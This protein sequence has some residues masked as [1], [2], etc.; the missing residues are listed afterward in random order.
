[1]EILEKEIEKETLLQKAEVIGDHFVSTAI[2]DKSK[3][4]CNWLGAR[5]IQDRQIA[6]YANRISALSPEFYSGSAGVAYFLMELYA[7]SQKGAYKRTAIAA[8]L[9]SAQYM[10]VNEFP[11][12]SISFYAGELGLIYIAYRFMEIAPEVKEEIKEQLDGLTSK[13]ERG[14][15]VNHSLDVIGG[16]SGAI[17]V[18]LHLKR[19]YGLPIFEKTALDCANEIV[20]LGN[21]KDDICVWSSP[22]VHGV[23]LD[24]PPT[25]GYS[26]G[27]SGIGV[28]LL[29]AYH[30]TKDKNYLRYG[31]GA[32]AF[33][34]ALFNEE[35]GNWIDTRYPH[36]KR[37]GQIT[38]TFRAAWCHGAP[39]IALANLRASFLDEERRDFHLKM[40]GIAIETT[41]AALINKIEEEPNKDATLCH[42][43]LGLS[44]IIYTYAQKVNDQ[45]LMQF[46][47]EMT[48]NYVS[49]FE[50]VISMPSG[51]VA[52][53]Y[54]PSVMV[55]HAGIGIHLLRLYSEA[56][57]NGPLMFVV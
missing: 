7:V 44:D 39:G 22:K 23:E 9:R 15:A 38:G 37:N 49:R 53:G 4:Y 51:I 48:S 42:G 33:E 55:G 20:E 24:T 21:W 41:K 11:A 43:I 12:S 50:D 2:W 16:N 40:A 46:S 6:K 5:D 47:A 52:G 17:P 30:F 31:R 25:T 1:M 54:S 27:A 34:N 57:I 3:T 14:M 35:K 13:L 8:W 36:K 29:E 19:K 28:G 56:V 32:F 18:L 45:N 26:H 10:K